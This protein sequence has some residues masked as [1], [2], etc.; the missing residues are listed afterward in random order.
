MRYK[1]QRHGRTI[2]FEQLEERCCL[3]FRFMGLNHGVLAFEGDHKSMILGG[4]AIGGLEDVLDA[5]Y[6]HGTPATIWYRTSDNQATLSGAINEYD[7]NTEIAVPTTP[8]SIE[9][10]GGLKNDT[11]N[12]SNADPIWGK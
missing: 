8:F 3:V 5:L 1:T 2:A 11:V 6:V 9:I 10:R 7:W 12:I 4:Q